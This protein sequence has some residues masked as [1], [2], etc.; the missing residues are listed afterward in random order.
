M[1]F[2]SQVKDRS[3]SDEKEV[4]AIT[5]LALETGWTLDYIRSLGPYQLSGMFKAIQQKRKDDFELI[6][7]AVNN[8]FGKKK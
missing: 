2:V 4:E 6:K 7:I 1:G 5:R 3:Q 8:A